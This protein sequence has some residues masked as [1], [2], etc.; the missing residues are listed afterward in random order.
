MLI[1]IERKREPGG[2]VR[3]KGL[4]LTLVGRRFERQ[5]QWAYFL[6]FFVIFYFPGVFVWIVSNKGNDQIKIAGLDC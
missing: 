1:I 4:A 3:R 2:V 6:L 5:Q